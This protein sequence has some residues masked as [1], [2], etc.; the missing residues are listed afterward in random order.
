MEESSPQQSLAEH[1][2]EVSGAL[3][4]LLLLVIGVIGLWLTQGKPLKNG[5][6]LMSAIENLSHSDARE[7][8]L[9]VPRAGTLVIELTLIRAADVSV[10]LKSQNTIGIEP[11]E[12]QPLK[13]FSA[14]RV[15]EYQ[16]SARVEPGDY[17]LILQASMPKGDTTPARMLIAA[18]WH[19]S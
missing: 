15:R 5:V 9:R 19:D 14:E 1:F 2:A 13:T 16:R 4:G 18:H 6:V 17:L 7:F 3:L 10:R 8:P 11:M 12:S